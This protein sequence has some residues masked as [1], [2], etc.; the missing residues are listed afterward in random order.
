MTTDGWNENDGDEEIDL[1]AWGD[2]DLFFQDDDE[3]VHP[4]T[5]AGTDIL[6]ETII[7]TTNEGPVTNMSGEGWDDLEDLDDAFKDDDDAKEDYHD[8][9]LPLTTTKTTTTLPTQNTTTAT[10]TT[11]SSSSLLQQ[12]IQLYLE[13]LE[14]LKPSLN[15]VLMQSVENDNNNNNNNKAY[16]LME[17]YSQR[18]AL[19][20]YTIQKELD[21]MEYTVMTKDGDC[22]TDKADIAVLLQHDPSLVAHC[23]N[24]S[25]LA[26]V[27]Q[28]CTGPDL[29]VRPQFLAAAV[30][31]QVQ[32]RLD[33]AAAVVQVHATLA[34]SLPT[35][36]GR[37]HVATVQVQV[38]FGCHSPQQ[39]FVEYHIH[40]IESTIP[41]EESYQ[42]SL[43]A[44]VRFVS[45]MNL[46]DDDLLAPPE[47]QQQQ[48]SSKAT[49]FRD[50]F[51]QQSQAVL[52]HSATGLQSAWADMDSVTGLS[53]KLQQIPR[54]LPND[55]VLEAALEQQEQQ[56]VHRPTSI[57]GGLMRTGFTKLAQSVVLPE[58]DPSMY[59][60]DSSMVSM[61]HPPQHDSRSNH[62]QYASNNPLDR[63]AQPHSSGNPLDRLVIQPNR[64][65]AP[66]VHPL[67][68]L[69]QGQ[70]QRSS[71]AA[72]SSI[73][74]N[75]LDRLAQ[76]HQQ[77]SSHAAPSS[78][79][80][81][82]LDRLT[83]GQQHP[84]ASIAPPN[85][86]DR[87]TQGQQQ[88]S[89]NVSSSVPPNSV[90]R[91]AQ[92]QHPSASIDPPNLLDRL[93]QLRSKPSTE[94]SLFASSLPRNNNAASYDDDQ[95][96]KVVEDG[97]D[98]VDDLD[99]DDVEEIV[100]NTNQSVASNHSPLEDRL[101]PD[102]KYNPADD[103]IPT[104]RRWIDPRPGIRIP[105][106]VR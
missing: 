35:D 73:P 32:F 8:S 37:W 57:L 74:P 55:V 13:Q 87:L 89:S 26:D 88:R 69:T 83:Q 39:A 79:L 46:H 49:D 96:D 54:F 103:I 98:D 91:L 77:R 67:D 97:W 30:A 42:S 99:L 21:R 86:L 40:S 19:R 6:H 85:P 61:K 2:N 34:L 78:I 93:T 82:P 84:S 12:E 15:A 22:V 100:V 27:L 104:R 58:E 62:N 10:T 66:V 64:A 33:L 5:L 101:P 72:P 106:P 48:P 50:L 45:S 31:T 1:D 29:L 92:G 60:S 52:T 51:M 18:P 71:R 94:S 76:G 36:Q 23:A 4:P 70:Q 41:K 28:L 90:D 75:P 81:N 53:H 43:D 47:Q 44:C 68:R 105:R 95:E 9:S 65:A 14:R 38:V 63:L 20:N 11:A 59:T 3:D 80:P 56:P 25:L 7:Q 102:F 24:Q 17:Y 16:E